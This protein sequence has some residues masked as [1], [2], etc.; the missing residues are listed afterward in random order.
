MKKVPNTLKRLV[1]GRASSHTNHT[2]ADIDTALWLT[3]PYQINRP[4][5]ARKTDLNN[6]NLDSNN[7]V[8][9]FSLQ[10]GNS[11]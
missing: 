4:T 7:K 11:N 6:D 3:N 8:A 1:L 5:L 9:F 2:K 10:V